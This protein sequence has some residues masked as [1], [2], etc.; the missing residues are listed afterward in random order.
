M[1]NYQ[2]QLAKAVNN[3]FKGFDNPYY[4]R[5][6][7]GKR[8]YILDGKGYSR[9]GKL[10]YQEPIKHIINELN[11][12][13]PWQRYVFDGELLYFNDD[14]IE[15]FRKGIS[16]SNSKDYKDECYNLVYVI[17]DIISR[18]CFI[19]QKSYEPFSKE[20]TNS[21]LLL[22]CKEMSRP[23]LIAT[24]HPHIFVARQ[25]TNPE[26][27]RNYKDFDKWEGLMVRDGDES[28]QFKRTGSLRK[29]KKFKDIEL[30]IADI[31]EGTGKYE[32]TLGSIV[33]SY[34]NNLVSVGS[35]FTDEQRDRIWNNWDD[36]KNMYLKVKYFEESANDNGEYS[37][38]FPTFLAFRD[39]ITK[40]EFT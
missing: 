2:V 21:I 40:E 35:G 30:P 10:C 20:Y 8:M 19:D 37:L 38:R 4:S 24:K 9:T 26:K 7:D 18:A 31:I 25:H 33:V 32:G 5:K 11:E 16:L 39:I 23:D 6:F 12:F 17:F 36:Y 34:R 22:D 13:D 29:I 27:L 15:D 28:Y 3:K 1:N 14:G